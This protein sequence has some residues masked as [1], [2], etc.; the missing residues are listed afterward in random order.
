MQTQQTTEAA[1][2]ST[3]DATTSSSSPQVVREYRSLGS[4]VIESNASL[5]GPED[6]KDF[7]EGEQFDVSGTWGKC[8]SATPRPAQ[9][10]NCHIQQQH[11]QE[12]VGCRPSQSAA[13][14]NACAA[15]R[16]GATPDSNM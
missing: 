7:W 11:V 5:S 2:S 4:K 3:A 12:Q 8:S 9:P 10:S 1:S 14:T 13:D 15:A 6:Q 16:T